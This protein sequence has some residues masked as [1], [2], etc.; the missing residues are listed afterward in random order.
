MGP[1]IGKVELTDQ[2]VWEGFGL[3]VADGG[4]GGV[5]GGEGDG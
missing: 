1:T 5:S 2:G 3:G 4:W